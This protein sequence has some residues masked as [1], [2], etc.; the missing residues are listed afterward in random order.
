MSPIGSIGSFP[1][2]ASTSGIRPAATESA[3]GFRE[4]LTGAIDRVEL[5]RTAADASTQ[6]FLRGEGENVHK[7]ALAAQQ[8]ELSLELFQQV[9]NKVVQ[10]Y[11]EVMRMQ[12]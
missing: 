5:S 3:S 2:L 4:A 11:Q 9:R 1:G 10:A 8:A 12:V 6:S 7:V